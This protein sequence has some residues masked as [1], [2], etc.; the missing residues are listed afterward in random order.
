MKQIIWSYWNHESLDFL[1]RWGDAND[2]IFT[3]GEWLP[4]WYERLHGEELIKKAAEMGINTIYTHFF[5]GFGLVHEH[6]DME[7]TRELVKIAHKYG[8]EVIGYVQLGSLVYETLIDEVPNL[9]D[10]IARNEKGEPIVYGTQYYRERPCLE[11]RELI[12]YYKKLFHYGIEHVGLDGFYF[13]GSSAREC[14]CEKCVKAFREYL[15]EHIKNPRE[16]VGLNNFNNVRIPP[17]IDSRPDEIHDVPTIYRG[18]FRHYQLFKAEKELFDYIREIGGKYVCQNPG[19][20]RRNFVT[21]SNPQLYPQSGNLVLAENQR[22]IAR[23][24][25]NNVT[26]VLAYKVAERFGY[27]ML[28]S[29]WLREEKPSGGVRFGIPKEKYEIDR[30]LAQGMIYGGISGTPWFVRSTKTGSEVIIDDENHFQAAKNAFNYFKENEKIYD[31]TSISQVKLL[32]NTDTFYGYVEKSY[33]FFQSKADWLND[34]NVPFVVITDEEIDETKLGDVIVIPD[35]K[36]ASTAQYEKLK[37]ASE[38]GVKILLFGQYG[39]C[40]ENG[41][42]R[43]RNSKI[44]N[45]KELDNVIKELPEDVKIKTDARNTLTEIRR[46]ANNNVTLHLL[47]IENENTLPFTNVEFKNLYLKK[48][49]KPVIYSLDEDCKL[50]SCEITDDKVCLKIRNLT[51]MITVEFVEQ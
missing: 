9:K 16:V 25:D 22:F 33:E 37:A 44:R 24:N 20:L 30:F 35:Y 7:K 39:I 18:R 21:Q 45:L 42:E 4:Q 50:E 36:S 13:D 26:N 2:S 41:K 31:S 19:Y 43:D 38:R 12:A 5:K 10:W 6:D 8:I 11:N 29:T 51:T 32:Y 15:T 46:N 3:F 1:R 49:V 48:D 17:Q 23:K 47:R 34:N 14:Y 40:N 27:K 28:D